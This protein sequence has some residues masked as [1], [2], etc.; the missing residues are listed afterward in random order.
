MRTF[1]QFFIGSS[2]KRTFET[3]D[4]TCENFAGISLEKAM[5]N[6]V[7]MSLNTSVRISVEFSV[8]GSQNTSGKTMET[9]MKIFLEDFSEYF[10]MNHWEDFCR[11]YFLNFCGVF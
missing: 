8:N 9:S 3:S 10:Y 2:H 11:D 4:E 7:K 1:V 5:K 6:S